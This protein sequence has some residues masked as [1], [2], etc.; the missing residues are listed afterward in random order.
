MEEPKIAKEEILPNK[1][2][3]QEQEQVQNAKAAQK[4]AAKEKKPKK[5]KKKENWIDEDFVSP[6]KNIC[7]DRP[8]SYSEYEEMKISWNPVTDYEVY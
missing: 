4:K 7:A 6:Y 8:E 1:K 5:E 3:G 2:E